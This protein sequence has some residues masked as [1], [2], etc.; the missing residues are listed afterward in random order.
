VKGHYLP[1]DILHRLI[2]LWTHYPVGSLGAGLLI[3]GAVYGILS[4]RLGRGGSAV[5]LMSFL[6]SAAL[7]FIATGVFIL[8]HSHGYQVF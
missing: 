8:L 1:N 2:G 3:L 4:W 6:L 5:M 7:I